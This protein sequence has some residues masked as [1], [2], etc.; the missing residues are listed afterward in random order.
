[1]LRSPEGTAFCQRVMRYV[2]ARWGRS[3][4]VSAFLITVMLNTPGAPELY[5][6]LAQMLM[7]CP[8]IAESGKEVLSLH[9]PV[10]AE[11]HQGVQLVVERENKK[12]FSKR[13]KNK[14][15]IFNSMFFGFYFS[16][17]NYGKPDFYFLFD[18]SII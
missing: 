14:H 16:S 15:I 11:G 10:V 3:R 12:V 5:E 18:S 17:V 13:R 8:S 6:Q 2:A 7:R 1:M 4:A 9:H